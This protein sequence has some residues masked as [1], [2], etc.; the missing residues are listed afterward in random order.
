MPKITKKIVI[1]GGGTG[2]SRV[3]RAL[4]DDV[5]NLSAIV[6]MADDGGST[7]RLRK[8]HNAPAVGDLRQCLLAFAD[9]DKVWSK[10]FPHRFGNNRWGQGAQDIEG[11][12]VGNII[13]VAL[14]DTLGGLRQAI[15]AAAD[16]MGIAASHGVYP[17]TFEN[18]ILKAKLNNGSQIGGQYNISHKI[19]REKKFK[20]ERVWLESQPPQDNPIQGNP[21][22]VAKIREA[23][24]ILIGPGALHGSVLPNLLIPD[25]CDAVINSK[26]KKIYIANTAVKLSETRGFSLED[27]IKTL[28]DHTAQ[29]LV[30]LI[31]VNSGKISHE[32]R[33]AMLTSN[34]KVIQGI[35]VRQA[36]LVDDSDIFVHDSLKL[37]KVLME[38]M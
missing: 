27:H 7:G 6:T 15:A 21:D 25:I 24:V 33:V 16:E 5:E 14:V 2:Q 29:N 28:L 37:K 34:K 19:P 30:D 38:V 36:D 17:S 31:V 22:A 10:I 4:K 23:N 35:V 13:L 3:I 26:A 9:P 11:H 12:V 8:F 1:I 20:I 32:K 18:V